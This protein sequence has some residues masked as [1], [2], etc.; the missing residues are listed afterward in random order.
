MA[1]EALDPLPT[2]DINDPSA[3]LADPSD[4]TATDDKRPGGVNNEKVAE[5]FKSRVAASIA[6]RRTFLTEWRRNVE[7][8]IGKLADRY[9]E[10]LA[11]PDD[12]RTELNPDWAR[13]KSTVANIFSAVG[14][15]PARFRVKT[16]RKR[17]A[18]RQQCPFLA[19]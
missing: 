15:P 7:L 12:I 5:R 13:T 9:T 2:A 19:K 8:R 6:H 3:S 18:V 16:A 1:F 14:T 17:H 4:P 11:D 10:G